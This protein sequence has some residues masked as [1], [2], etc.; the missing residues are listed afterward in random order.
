M[1][2]IYATLIVKG[3][4]TSDRSRIKLRTRC[5]RYWLTWS[6]KN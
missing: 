4:K 6:V 1:A 5:A 3:R 2:V